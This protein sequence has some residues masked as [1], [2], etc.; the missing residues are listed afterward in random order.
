MKSFAESEVAIDV[1]VTLD[2]WAAR[3]SA[4]AI[5]KLVPSGMQAL[6]PGDAHWPAALDDLGD[7]RPLVLWVRGGCVATGNQVAADRRRAGCDGVR[8]ARDHGNQLPRCR[9]RHNGAVRRSLR[10][11]RH[12]PQGRAGLARQV[13][14]GGVDRAYP[15]GHAAL[16]DR[17]ADQGALVSESLPGS[18]PTRQRGPISAR[19]HIAASGGSGRRQLGDDGTRVCSNDD[20]ICRILRFDLVLD[21]NLLLLGSA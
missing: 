9:R 8:R 3:H 12:G 16:V 11:R 15:A 1:Q 6:I 19:E 21:V 5:S 20:G 2:R 13:L 14:A 17:I 7:E 4:A 10:H 18:A